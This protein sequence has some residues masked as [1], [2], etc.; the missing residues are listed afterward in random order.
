MKFQHIVIT[1]FS[2]RG[3]EAFKRLHWLGI[4]FTV[5]P[6]NP[7]YLDFRMVLFEMTCLQG[8]LNQSTQDFTWI[9]IIDKEL[10]ENYKQKLKSCIKPKVRAFIWEYD[11]TV[12]IESIDWLKPYLQGNPDYLVTSNL[13]DDDILPFNFIE[14]C[15]KHVLE[16]EQNNKLPTLKLIGNKH[17]IQWNLVHSEDA[18]LGWRSPWHRGNFYS[19][20]GF[21]LIGKYPVVNFNVLGIMHRMAEKYIDFSLNPKNKNIAFHQNRFKEAFRKNSEDFNQWTKNDL[22]FD[23][24]KIAG[25][26]LMTNHKFN[27]QYGRLYEDKSEL[28]KVTGPETFPEFSINWEFAKKHAPQFNL[29]KLLYRKRKFHHKLI[30]LKRKIKKY[31]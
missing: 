11:P 20:C 9:I 27:A 12:R 28:I 4:N 17:I 25:P 1:L 22:L 29:D 30:K 19:S 26:V 15:K 5:N 31:L 14:S 16:I 7:K 6:L 18:P 13:D 10:P 23:L 2:F 24:A 8:I 21:S 3:K